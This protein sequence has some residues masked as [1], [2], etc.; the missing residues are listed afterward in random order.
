[1]VSG[2]GCEKIYPVLNFKDAGFPADLLECTKG[3]EKPT[4]IQS[5]VRLLFGSLSALRVFA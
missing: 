2:R 3:F 4:P 5:Q 1:M